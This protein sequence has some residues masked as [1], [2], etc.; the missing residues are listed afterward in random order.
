MY[1]IPEFEWIAVT[2]VR[3]AA[4]TAECLAHINYPFINGVHLIPGDSITLVYPG[5]F[6]TK[7]DK[8]PERLQLDLN[9]FIHLK[10]DGMEVLK[11][12]EIET[13]KDRSLVSLSAF[14]FTADVVEI[15]N[16]VEGLYLILK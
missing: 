12:G 13:N 14:E 9:F 5:I 11:L 1:N 10:D 2:F 4:L 7:E 6:Y 16:E 15:K 3:C 8:L